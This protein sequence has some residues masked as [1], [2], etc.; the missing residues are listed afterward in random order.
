M[1]S[2]YPPLSRNGKQN[3]NAISLYNS[4]PAQPGRM[5]TNPSE[6][7]NCDTSDRPRRRRDAQ[8]ARRIVDLRTRF[9]DLILKPRSSPRFLRVSASPKK[10]DGPFVEKTAVSPLAQ[11]HRG[12]ARRG[13][14]AEPW[15][16]RPWRNELG[17][18]VWTRE[19]SGE[20]FKIFFSPRFLRVS[21]VKARFFLHQTGLPAP[22]SA[23]KASRRSPSP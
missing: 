21:A 7:R 8:K 15:P 18:L 16:R 20:K 19:V 9:S 14:I 3:P 5:H 12:A 23:V 10:Q 6:A 1:E 11:V 17:N 22:C 4:A 2:R 13:E